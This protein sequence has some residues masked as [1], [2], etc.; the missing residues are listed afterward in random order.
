MHVAVWH[1]MRQFCIDKYI[2]ATTQTAH[3][4]PALQK[5]S[6][7]YAYI[8]WGSSWVQVF[9]FWLFFLTLASPPDLNDISTMVA[10]S[11]YNEGLVFC[12]SLFLVRQTASV[13]NSM[14]YSSNSWLFCPHPQTNFVVLLGE[15][16]LHWKVGTMR[17]KNTQKKNA[18]PKERL[19]VSVTSD[20]VC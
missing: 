4:L 10:K 8:S 19:V 12:W 1:N 3:D 20:F 6:S 14:T 13:N 11:A 17:K 5:T 2:V 9:G 16:T 18:D 15:W 7:T